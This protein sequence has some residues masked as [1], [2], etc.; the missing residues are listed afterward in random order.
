MRRIKKSIGSALLFTMVGINSVSFAANYFTLIPSTDN[1]IVSAGFTA[2]V[3]Y[4]I[5]NTSGAQQ[6]QITYQPNFPDNTGVTINSALSDCGSTLGNGASCDLTL[7]IQAPNQTTTY[8]LSPRVC[9]HNGLICSVP[10]AEN[11]TQVNVVD[12]APIP[13][14]LTVDLLPGNQNLQFRALELEN[15]G[16]EAV[17]L[18]ALTTTLA[19]SF[20]GKVERC[21]AS[22]GCVPPAGSFP[23]CANG[24]N[25]VPGGQCL[26]W[27]RSI[28]NTDA[29]GRISGSV[30]VQ[31]V[32]NP[33]AV[34]NNTTF[35]IDYDNDVYAGG[36]FTTASGGTARRIARWNGT[37][38][39]P[40]S[41][42]MNQRV[43]AIT[44]YNGNLVAGGQFTNA[45]G[46]S[47]IRIAQWNGV[48]WSAL[49]T[50]V[51]STVR[52][53]TVFNNNLIAGGQ[54]TTAGGNS[55]NR[56]A[57]WN[58]TTWSNLGSGLNN[59][60][61]ALTL[62]NGNLIVGG[63]FSTAG[64]S[65]ASEIAQWNGA[66][67]S[68]LGAG[69]NNTVRA[70]T[71]FNG[72]LV[73]GGQFTN[74]GGNSANRVARWNGATW[75]N[76]GTGTNNQVRALTVFNGNLIAG[77]Q[78][79]NAG[80]NAAARIAQWDGANWSALGSGVSGGGNPRIFAL[81]QID[82]FLFAGGRFTNAGGNSAN[83]TAQWNGA[84][85]SSLGTG[86]NNQVFALTI[87]SSLNIH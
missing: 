71:L 34:L 38:W 46:N 33:T 51:N 53:L 79:T 30:M 67:W 83:R 56:V 42:G 62:F 12:T 76:F 87:A 43:R 32:T 72:E 15:A 40:L 57:E 50:G 22:T 18:T 28:D 65:P 13:L 82:A 68:A 37:V 78:F 45:G 75:S 61:W 66:A 52:A 48:N 73:A 44:L 25:L 49:G 31:I 58:G 24:S 55:A 3:T 60:V 27:F 20:N 84:A 64:G 35:T 41:T 81:T 54:F 19:A 5:T 1:I 17:T 7:T 63:Q 59:Q 11:R 21:D 8:A 47:A 10:T 4:Q 69:T 29:V 9:S 77:G 23:P 70:L 2:Q 39:S 36:Q 6:T 14:D 80:G 85:W 86:M 16:G 26:I 74:A